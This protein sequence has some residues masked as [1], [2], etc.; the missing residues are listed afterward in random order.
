MPHSITVRVIPGKIQSVAI[1]D[2]DNIGVALGL[3]EGLE[4]LERYEMKIDDEDLDSIEY[5]PNGD[6]TVD[7]YYHEPEPEPPFVNY[8]PHCAAEGLTEVTSGAF[9]CGDCDHTFEISY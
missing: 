7:L 5:V 4:D 3:C 2:G 1:A 8:C 9:S 6:C